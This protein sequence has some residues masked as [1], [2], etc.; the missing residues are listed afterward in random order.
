MTRLAMVERAGASMQNQAF[1]ALL[2]LLREDLRTDVEEMDQTVK[3]R[4]GLGQA[5]GMLVRWFPRLPEIASLQA[6]GPSL[7]MTNESEFPQNLSSPAMLLSS[8]LSPA[9][10][11]S[12]IAG[13]GG[14]P[15][16]SPETIIKLSPGSATPD[17]AIHQKTG[18]PRLTKPASQ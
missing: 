17:Q 7:A 9:L 1:S 3:S 8:L 4:N 5:L 18:L 16:A 14:Q 13:V 6:C 12:S 2:L 11:R 10:S 15:G